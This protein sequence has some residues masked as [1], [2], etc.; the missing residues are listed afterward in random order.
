MRIAWLIV[1][2]GVIAITAYFMFQP[3][4]E[5]CLAPVPGP[6]GAEICQQAYFARHW[7][8]L[9]GYP[10]VVGFLLATLITVW[11]SK[12]ATSGTT[13]R[14]GDRVTFSDAD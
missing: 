4:F 3:P 1:G 8:Q 7:L 11:W 6:V 10:Q 14:R 13:W 9:T 12:R 5:S 2:Y